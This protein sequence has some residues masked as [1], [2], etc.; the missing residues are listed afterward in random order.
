MTVINF[1][2]CISVLFDPSVMYGHSQFDLI[3]SHME[4]QFED[5]FFEEY[6]KIIPRGPHW[7][8]CL[9]VY[10]FFYHLVSWYHIGEE[11]CKTLT[12]QAADSVK[13]MIERAS[14]AV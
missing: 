3:L 10:E 2:F 8:N 9:K 4:A 6:H 14:T 7:D 13:E 12:L 1:I 5:T 11:S